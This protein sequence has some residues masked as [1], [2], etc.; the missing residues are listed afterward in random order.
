MICAFSPYKAEVTNLLVAMLRLTRS[1]EEHAREAQQKP[2]LSALLL[3]LFLEVSMRK[4]KVFVTRLSEEDRQI[5]DAL[6]EKTRRT[7]SDVI[8][9]ALY[10]VASGLDPK[11]AMRVW[12]ES[13]YEETK[14]LETTNR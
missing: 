5:L 8:R 1:Q 9:W 3:I 7:R 11:Q 14:K 6:A 2:V 10:E 4:D 12:E 13:G